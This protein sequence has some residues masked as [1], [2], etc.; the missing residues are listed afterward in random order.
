[1]LFGEMLRVYDNVLDVIQSSLWTLKIS[2]FKESSVYI[3]LFLNLEEITF[4]CALF[5]YMRTTTFGIRGNVQW[6]LES[7]K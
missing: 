3:K 1:M 4:S 6:W 2:S 5:K 7:Y